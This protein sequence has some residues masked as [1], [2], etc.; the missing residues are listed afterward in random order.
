MVQTVLV[1]TFL[2]TSFIISF[3]INNIQKYRS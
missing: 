2:D 1:L 3:L